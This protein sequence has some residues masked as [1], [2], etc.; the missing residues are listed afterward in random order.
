[1]VSAVP[2]SST[3]LH[4][5]VHVS[6]SATASASASV[7]ASASVSVSASAFVF[8]YV[9][10]SAFASVSVSGSVSAFAYVS[11]SASASIY[12]SIAFFFCVLSSFEPLSTS[13]FSILFT[14]LSSVQYSRRS[15]NPGHTHI[16]IRRTS[17]IP[18]VVIRVRKSAMSSVAATIDGF[19][20]SLVVVLP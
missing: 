18:V 12:I 16:G 7:P 6:A 5:S 2:A 17:Y 11:L 20:G 9:S 19:S 14:H 8:V 1:M 3:V 15:S 10:A 13:D 4:A